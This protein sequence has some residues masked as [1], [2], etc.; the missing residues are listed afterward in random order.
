MKF[1]IIPNEQTPEVRLHLSFSENYM[2]YSDRK[3]MEKFYSFARRQKNCAGLAANQVSVD[4]T[5]I[6]KRF[7][8][9]KV[10]GIWDIIINPE[11]VNYQGKKTQRFEGCL[12]WLGKSIIADRFPKI[13]V[14]YFNLKGEKIEREVSGLEA[15]VWQHEVDHLNG[16]EERIQPEIEG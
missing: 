9:I 10:N 13:N 15:Q 14:R 8:A 6:M 12:S 1:K 7:F 5:R 3:L 11:I 16:V 4:G 2:I